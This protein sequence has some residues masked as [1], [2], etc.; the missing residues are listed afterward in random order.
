MKS[1]GFIHNKMICFWITAKDLPRCEMGD[2]K[3]LSAVMTQIVQGHANGHQG[4]AIPLLEPLKITAMDIKQGSNS[5]IS[6][7]LH[8]KNMDLSGLSKAEFYKVV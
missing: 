5:P 7:E 1:G 3:C 6:I 8:F 4:L 2:V